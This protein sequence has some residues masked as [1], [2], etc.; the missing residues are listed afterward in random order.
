MFDIFGSSS[1]RRSR[2]LLDG[3][4]MP[5][6][7]MWTYP[8]VREKCG[9]GAYTETVVFDSETASQYFIEWRKTHGCSLRRTSKR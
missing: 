9:C 3:F 1:L 5:E 8:V 4:T 2:Q 6:Q 7:S